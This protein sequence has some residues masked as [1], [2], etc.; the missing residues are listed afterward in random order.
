LDAVRD[1]DDGHG[2]DDDNYQL[3]VAKRKRQWV[4]KQINNGKQTNK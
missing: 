4:N 1:D 3:P 2:D